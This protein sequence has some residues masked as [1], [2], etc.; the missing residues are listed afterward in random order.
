MEYSIEFLNTIYRIFY[1]ILK[2]YI[3]Y[4]IGFLNTIYRIFYRIWDIQ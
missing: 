3:E 4:S 1:R 2:F